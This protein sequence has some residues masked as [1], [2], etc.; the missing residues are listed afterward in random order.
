MDRS[1]SG[2]VLTIPITEVLRHRKESKNLCKPQRRL[3]ERPPKTGRIKGEEIAEKLRRFY[4]KN[5]EAYPMID[6]IFNLFG[7]KKSAKNMDNSHQIMRSY[8]HLRTPKN[9]RKNTI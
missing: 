3:K 2:K 4:R 7:G 9:S 5:Q 6:H 1:C 8:L